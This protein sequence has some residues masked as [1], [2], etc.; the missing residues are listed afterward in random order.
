MK[1]TLIYLEN[2]LLS[3]KGGPYAVG[4]YIQQQ[5]LKCHKM[6]IEFLKKDIESK[7]EFDF[8]GEWYYKLLQNVFRVYK[9]Y[10]RFRYAIEVGGYASID[11]SQ[12]D[13]VHFHKTID[14]F[15]NRKSLENFKGLIILTSHSPVPLSMEIYEEHLTKLEKFI[16]RS[17]YSRLIEIDKYAFNRADYILFPNEEAEEPYICNWPGYKEIRERRKSHYVYIP[18]GI[19]AACAKRSRLQIRKEL[20]IDMND[21]YISYV[22]RH[23]YVKGYD[24][25]CE[26]GRDILQDGN[27]WVVVAGKEAPLTRLNH[28]CWIEIGWTDDAHSYIAASDVFLLPNRETYFDIVMLEVL[29][30]GKIVVASRTGGNKYFEHFK[31]NGVFLYDSIDE[32]LA[33]LRSIRAMPVKVRMD[34]GEQNRKMFNEHF[35]DDI[36]VKRYC[37]FLES[38]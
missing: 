37:S 36:F 8:T 24:K 35:R 28:N 16:F 32:A 13:I 18:T 15:E 38:L 30:L 3:P 14:L 26:I 25:L 34:L 1:K 4:Y 9:R 19:P 2:T 31:P 6:N 10:R 23:N 12:Y 27:T 20:G 17:L 22:G 7:S 29:S 5:L 21:F 11:L 33:I